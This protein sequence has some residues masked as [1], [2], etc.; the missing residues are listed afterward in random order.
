[1]AMAFIVLVGGIYLAYLQV[2]RP[3]SLV[4]QNNKQ[5]ADVQQQTSNGSGGIN[6][7]GVQGDVAV[8][9]HQERDSNQSSTNMT[10]D[11]AKTS[12]K[13][14]VS[15]P[16][17]VSTVQMHTAIHKETLPSDQQKQVIPTLGSVT[18]N[19]DVNQKNVGG[20]NQLAIGNNNTV[21]CTPIPPAVVVLHL[22]KLTAGENPIHREGDAANHPG[23]DLTFSVNETFTN[24]MF[25][26]VCDR[27]CLATDIK[28]RSM[29]FSPRT[30]ST[31]SP[32]VVVAAIG[33]STPLTPGQ[34]VFLRIRSIDDRDV[35]VISVKGYVPTSQ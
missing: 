5:K 19:G 12:T 2:N 22:D 16:S 26:V 27:P 3:S 10:V 32:N 30:F 33:S 14:K 34:L 1:M 35:S 4:A 31:S 24:P 8:T 13:L 28:A 15:L 25:M 9:V 23:V 18:V 17:A 6:I 29:A 7:Q 20:C 21:N 11:S